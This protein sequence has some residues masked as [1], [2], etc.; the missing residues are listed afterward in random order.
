[1]PNRLQNFIDKLFPETQPVT[2]VSVQT[3][4]LEVQKVA[5]DR[6]TNGEKSRN[7]YAGDGRIKA[8]IQ[9][10]ARDM[11][12]QSLE[13]N[14]KNSARGEKIANALIKRIKLSQYLTEWCRTALIDGDVFL[15]LKHNGNNIVE[16]QKMPTFYISKNVDEFMQFPDKSAAYSL[17]E[18]KGIYTSAKVIR[19]FNAFEMVHA[20]WD[21]DSNR[22]YG[23]PLFMS[24]VNPFVRAIDGENDMYVK[25]R[26]RA[27]A[28]YLHNL[29][30][31]SEPALE[32][33]KTAH[34]DLLS[35]P[36]VAISDFFTNVKGSIQLIEPQTRFDDIA[37]VKHHIETFLTSSPVPSSLIGYGSD[38]SR[39]VLIAQQLAYAL[40]VDHLTE[41]WM[42]PQIVLPLLE[43]EWLL[44]GLLPEN[45]EWEAYWRYRVI[46]SPDELQKL[47]DAVLRLRAA[48]FSEDLIAKLV[49][50]YVPNLTVQELINN[51]KPITVDSNPNADRS[52]NDTDVNHTADVPSTKDSTGVGSSSK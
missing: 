32:A 47:A 11:A 9:M 12:K 31:A 38:V 41:T 34:K 7:M 22:I 24:S 26:T 37:D 27:G 39:D 13:I 20:Q 49:A 15:W 43:R 42:L 17:T 30:G 50:R 33:Y 5:N 14:V 44:N 23:I 6:Y 19:N 25:R 16:I 8:S 36:L 48:G 40:N 29:E 52:K 28:R 3:L 1:M 18:I 2:K 35:N 10:M 51:I 4:S 21:F 46:L 45:M